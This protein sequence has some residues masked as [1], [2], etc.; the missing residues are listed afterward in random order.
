MEF[1]VKDN[2]VSDHTRALIDAK[3]TKAGVSVEWSVCGG[4]SLSESEKTALR[5]KHKTRNVNYARAA[6]VKR[7]M[8]DGKTCM[9]IVYALSRKYGQTMI[10][11]DHAALSGR[12]GL[13]R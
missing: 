2:I 1:I 6:A 7:L 3:G 13:K 10:K 5:R 4:D 11:K 8:S 9:Q 12:G